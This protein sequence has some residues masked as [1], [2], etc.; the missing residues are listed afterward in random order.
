M[1]SPGKWP[2][3]YQNLGLWLVLARMEASGISSSITVVQ[4]TVVPNGI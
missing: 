3:L 4:V 2:S 1:N